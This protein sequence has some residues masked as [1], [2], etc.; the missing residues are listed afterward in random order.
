VGHTPWEI[1][2]S[3]RGIMWERGWKH[4]GAA[5]GVSKMPKRS[6]V[7]LIESE[8]DLNSARYCRNLDRFSP[9]T[10]LEDIR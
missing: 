10:A 5:D 2:L 9:E 8:F 1:Q 4:Q 3:I 7:D 6:N